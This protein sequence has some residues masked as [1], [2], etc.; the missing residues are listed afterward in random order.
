MEKFSYISK[1]QILL[2]T[3]II[4]FYYIF[5]K[6]SS[7]YLKYA[8]LLM[9]LLLM[10]SMFNFFCFTREIKLEYRFR[11]IFKHLKP[12]A[13]IF[14]TVALSSVYVSLD[15]FFLGIFSSSEEVAYYHVAIKLTR[16]I[17]SVLLAGGVVISVK[18][19]EKG[20]INKCKKILRKY[21]LFIL[22]FFL[23]ASLGLLTFSKELIFIIAGEQYL[24][25]IIIM[26][27]LS[28]LLLLI[29]LSNIFG[30]QILYSFGKDKEVILSIFLSTLVN[31][32]LNIILIP[33][34][35]ALGACIGTIV[36]EVVHVYVLYILVKKFL[37][38]H[39]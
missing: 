7:D 2:N 15:T 6:E 18:I 9:S 37:K 31:I 26:K 32:L 39:F 13:I 28:I 24:N 10:N 3:F 25:S 34:Y 14:I 5:I 29:G 4:P 12:M 19:S 38:F 16:M 27:L 33:K 1:R 21:F 36:T 30:T 20:D 23:P 22:L 17:I 35:G 8:I 11:E